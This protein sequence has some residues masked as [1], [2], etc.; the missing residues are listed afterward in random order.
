M[1]P[2][3]DRHKNAFVDQLPSSSVVDQITKKTSKN[4]ALRY[5]RILFLKYIVTTKFHQYTE[6]HCFK[7]RYF[8]V[9]RKHRGIT[10]KEH[11]RAL[12]SM[13]LFASRL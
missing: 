12:N 4:A 2:K 9:E 10:I 6:S 5:A 11:S 1:I 13:L 3:I 8:E 7:D